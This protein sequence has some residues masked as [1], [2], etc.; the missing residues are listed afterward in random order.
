VE[1]IGRGWIV[2]YLPRSFLG[3]AEDK[4]EKHV[5]IFDASAATAN[6]SPP[7]LQLKAASSTS[8]CFG[9]ATTLSIQKCHHTD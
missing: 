2:G 7:T 6:R 1:R 4:R 3:S 5:E 8:L 9:N